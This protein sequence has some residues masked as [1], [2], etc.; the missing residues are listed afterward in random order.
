[1]RAGS[2]PAGAVTRRAS[3]FDVRLR[4]RVEGRRSGH[5]R[6]GPGRRHLASTGHIFLSEDLRSKVA[7]WMPPWRRG[8]RGCCSWARRASTRNSR[9]PADPGARS[10]PLRPTN[11]AYA[12]AK[13]MASRGQ[14]VRQR[15]PAVDLGDGLAGRRQQP[16]LL[17]ALI[18]RYDGPKPV[19]RLT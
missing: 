7:C 9:P 13:I 2:W 6:G 3:G 18:R 16:H 12:I 17:P 11:D 8:C 1:M 10:C 19:A 14:A 4:S 5:R 15:G